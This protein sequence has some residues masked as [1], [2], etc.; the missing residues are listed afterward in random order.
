M[1]SYKNCFKAAILASILLPALS[2]CTN[3][4]E[5]KS[6]IAK[7]VKSQFLTKDKNLSKTAP[8]DKWWL[9]FN[10]STLNQLIDM[11]LKNNRDIQ[12]ANQ[13]IIT[14]RQLN[15][16]NL[17]TL[18]PSGTVGISRQRFS[19]PGFGPRGIS[20]D[21]FQSTFDAT[22]ELDFF[23]KNLDRYKAGKLRFLKEA[24][25]YKANSLRVVSEISQNYFALKA[26]QK[27]IEN[28]Q[29]IADLRQKLTVIAQGKEKVGS[30]SKVNI[31]KAE[32]D[33]NN[34]ES[35][36]ID[37]KTNEKVLTY[38]LAVLAGLLPE[39]V[40]EILRDKN[41]K[42]IFNYYSG[43]VPVGLKSD[44][45][46]RRPDIIAA[47]Y[48]IDAALYDKSAQFKEFLPS[49]NLTARIGGGATNLG[50]MLKN[51]ANVKDIRGGVSVPLLSAGQ[52]LAEYKISKAKGKIAVLDYEKTVLSAIE[53][54]E[55]QL[56]RYINALQ[57]ENNT[58]NSLQSS[59]KIL[60]I[61]QNKKRLGVISNEELINAEISKLSSENMLAQKKSE[62]L[63]NLVAVHKAL[64]GGFEGYEMKFENDRVLWIN[65]ESNKLQ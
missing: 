58:Q 45:L 33:H 41:S 4:K 37:A 13:S 5:Y 56:T 9:E 16:I 3:D 46:K 51:G 64:G 44:I 18:L 40:T 29:K 26:T 15:N 22:W 14:S 38:K 55:S 34:A 27:Q 31:H 32:I 61:N 10:D 59:N 43:L 53:E 28:L 57:V 39:Q 52:L 35:A 6:T 50:D 47:E 60:R 24:Q 49:F 25:L 30:A 21:L 54:T 63:A 11:A 8:A 42:N 7:D 20:Y 1:K 65:Q 36:L 12:I 17:T 19:S 2:S 23:G 48:E 62:T